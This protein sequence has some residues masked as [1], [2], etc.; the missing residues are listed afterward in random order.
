MRKNC[1]SDWEK[2]NR[3]WRPRICKYFE[4]TR[5]ICSNRERSEQF[6]VT[7]WFFNL[8]LE[9]CHIRKIYFFIGKVRKVLAFW[10]YGKIAS[11][12]FSCPRQKPRIGSLIT[13]TLFFVFENLLIPIATFVSLKLGNLLTSSDPKQGSLKIW[14]EHSKFPLQGRGDSKPPIALLRSNIFLEKSVKILS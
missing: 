1:S 4:I 3:G 2:Q 9:A 13:F 12:K 7:E 5:T 6:L 8:F 14:T 11:W 10:F